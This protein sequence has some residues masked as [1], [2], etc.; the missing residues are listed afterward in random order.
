MLLIVP[1]FATLGYLLVEVGG[2]NSKRGREREDLPK[3]LIVVGGPFYVKLS[4]K[5]N[6]IR[7]LGGKIC[8]NMEFYHPLPTIST[9]LSCV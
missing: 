9:F 4:Y 5:K 7:D 1:L 8:R 2:Y 3:S 6:I